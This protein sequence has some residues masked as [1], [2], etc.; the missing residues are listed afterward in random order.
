MV[1]VEKKEKSKPKMDDMFADMMGGDSSDDVDL[2][3]F[4]APPKPKPKPKPEEETNNISVID[5]NFDVT[6]E[7]RVE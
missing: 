1:E 4:D 7:K 2:M 3:D 6:P 5:F